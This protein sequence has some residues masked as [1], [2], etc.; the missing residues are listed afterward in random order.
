MYKVLIVD[1]NDNNRLTLNLLLEEVEDIEV[2]EAEDGQVAVEMCVKNDFDL[3]FVDIM[4]PNLD[5]F[6][7]T[8]YIKQVNKKC[9]IIA[10]SALDDD[11]VSKH[12]MLSLG[13]EDYLTK[14]LNADHFLQRIKQYRDWETDR[15]STRLNSSHFTRSRMPSSA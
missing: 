13:A 14:P 8:K 9:M 2:Y 6:E 1:D 4:M 7:A 5:G 3:I 10:L 12:K 15:K 11:E